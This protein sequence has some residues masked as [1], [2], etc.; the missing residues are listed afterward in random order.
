MSN[1]GFEAIAHE[2]RLADTSPTVEHEVSGS[3]SSA[4]GPRAFLKTVGGAVLTWFVYSV[5]IGV[6]PIGLSVLL[7]WIRGAAVS[8][9]L[10]GSGDLLIVSVSVVAGAVATLGGD[11]RRS[12]GPTYRVRVVMGVSLLITAI[13][14]FVY[15]ISGPD[16]TLSEVEKVVNLSI[17][18][19]TASVL[20]GVVAVGVS[21]SSRYERLV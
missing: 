13:A 18:L 9:D 21:A 16:G 15:G 7:H 4:A 3:P 19:F 1:T 2:D 10:L 5:L 8:L 11:V 17:A 6:L 14:A 20:L 12:D